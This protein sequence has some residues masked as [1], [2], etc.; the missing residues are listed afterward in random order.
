MVMDYSDDSF[1][2]T[3]LQCYLFLHLESPKFI[4]A[5]IFENHFKKH[6]VSTP[7]SVSVERVLSSCISV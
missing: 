2:I 1:M 7:H 3:V 4:S 6:S 5:L